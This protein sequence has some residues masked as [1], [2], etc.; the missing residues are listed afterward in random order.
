MPQVLYVYV[1]GSDL[2]EHGGQLAAA[3]AGLAEKWKDRGAFLVNQVHERTADMCSSDLPDWFLGINMP[4]SAFGA[5]EV[6]ELVPFLRGLARS[7]DREF[8]VGLAEE[9][10]ITEDLVFLGASSGERQRQDLLLHVAAL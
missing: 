9:S 7:T 1:D 5:G 10:G 8:V 6:D 3:F 2:Q 4:S